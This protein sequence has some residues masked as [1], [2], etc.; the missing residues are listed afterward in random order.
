MEQ[1]LNHLIVLGGIIATM[2]VAYIAWVV[3]GVGNMAVKNSLKN[4]SWVRFRK[5][6]IKF[7]CFTVSMMACSI[8]SDVLS[9]YI[10]MLEID[11]LNQFMT[12][13]SWSVIVGIPIVATV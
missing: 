9:Y 6:L 5:D 13:I 10:A 2:C 1:V 3:S 7:V 4:W 11:A 8:V 12:V